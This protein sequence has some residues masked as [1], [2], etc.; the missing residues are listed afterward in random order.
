MQ[1]FGC[2]W[3]PRGVRGR[4]DRGRDGRPPRDHHQIKEAQL[5]PWAINTSQNKKTAAKGK[6]IKVHWVATQR[7]TQNTLKGIGKNKLIVGRRNV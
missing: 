4:G 1:E 5:E 6:H 2:L 7:Q 3:W